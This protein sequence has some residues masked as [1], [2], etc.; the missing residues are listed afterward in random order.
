MLCRRHGL[1]NL[2]RVARHR[3]GDGELGGI[4]MIAAGGKGTRK[5]R[6]S[7]KSVEDGGLKV[8]E[9]EGEG[10]KGVGEIKDD[11]YV[12]LHVH[13]DFSLLD[14]A[15][16][17]ESLV[18][19]AVQMDIPA[20]ALTDHGVLYGAI[21]L[22]RACEKKGIKP[23][24]GNEMYMMNEEI[25]NGASRESGV[26]VKKY[27][28][29]VLAKNTVG[30]QNLVKLTSIAHLE[31]MR[32]R[33][34]FARPC[35]NKELL[36][37][38]R[39]GLIVCSACLG[40]EIPQA[41]LQGDLNAAERV[42]RWYRNL[43]GPD[44]YLELQDHARDEDKIVNEELVRL[45]FKLGIPLIA[46]N[47]SHFTT[48]LDAPAHDAL[49]CVKTGKLL[50]DEK[51]LRYT[52]QEFFKSAAEMRSMFVE[53]LPQR[54]VDKALQ[55]TVKL[56]GG[57][58]PYKIHAEKVIPDFPLPSSHSHLNHD[59]YLT[60]LARDGL[61]AI[62]DRRRSSAIAEEQ[63]RIYEERLEYELKMII[64]MGFTS[65]FLVVWDYIR[66]ARD[67]KIPV[68]PGRGS[69]AGSLVAF[70]LGITGIDPVQ[71]G[72]LFERFL[73]PDRNS[74]PDID[75]D[76][77]VEGREKVIEYVTNKYG[78]DRVA[79]I[80]TFNRLTTKAVLKDV[81]RVHGVSYSQA[82]ELAK[83]VPVFR[84]KPTT[85]TELIGRDLDAE[86]SGGAERAGKPGRKVAGAFKDFREK[87]NK[88]GVKEWVEKA[89]RIEGIN[90]G[91]SVHAAGV[92]ISSAPLTNLVPL[93]RAKHGEIIT[94]YPMEDVE[95]VGLLKMDFLGLK[96]LSVIEAVVKLINTRRPD[97][98][99][100]EVFDIDTIPMDDAKT[101]ELLASGFLDGVF[102][103]DASVGMQSIVRELAPSS[104]SDISSV[105]ALYRPG[106]LDAGLIPKFIARKHGREPIEYAHKLLE[107]IL[108]ETYGI[109]VY[110]EQIMSTAQVI[111]GY[112]MAQADML[113]RAMGKKKVKEM[114]EQRPR[115][116]SGAVK[117]GV[118]EEIATK[119][120]E[121]MMQFAHYC[122]NKSH[123]TAYAYLTYQ[124][125]YLKA[126]YPVEYMAGLLAACTKDPDRLQRLLGSASD[127]GIY[128]RPPDVN[129]SYMGFT[130]A[131]PEDSNPVI[132]FGLAAISGVGEG[133]ANAILQERELNGDYSS[134][135]ELSSRLEGRV[136]NK[137]ALSSLIYAGAFDGM[138]FNRK[139][140]RE[141]L[142]LILECRKKVRDRQAARER[143]SE[144]ERQK[145]MDPEASKSRPTLGCAVERCEEQKKLEWERAEIKLKETQAN[146][147]EWPLVEKLEYEKNAIG[148]Y[149]SGHPLD[150]LDSFCKVLSC[151]NTSSVAQEKNDEL[152]RILGVVTGLK[153]QT[154]SKGGK[155]GRLTIEDKIGRIPAI[156]FPSQYAVLE[157]RREN[158]A[159]SN[160]MSESRKIENGARVVV[161]GKIS[162]D[163]NSDG[164]LIVDDIIPVEDVE[165]LV[166]DILKSEC[167]KKVCFLQYHVAHHGGEGGAINSDEGDASFE[168]RRYRRRKNVDLSTKARIPVVVRK[169]GE[170]NSDESFVSLPARFR[171]TNS[172][173][174]Q[175]AIQSELKL[176]A[177]LLNFDAIQASELLTKE[178]HIEHSRNDDLAE[179]MDEEEPAA[180]SERR[181]A[182][183]RNVGEKTNLNNSSAERNGLVTRKLKS[184]FA[185]ILKRKNDV[186]VCEVALVGEQSNSEE[187][188]M[189]A[190]DQSSK[191][192]EEEEAVGTFVGSSDTSSK[193]KVQEPETEVANS[194]GEVVP[195][196][197]LEE[198]APKESS[199]DL[200]L[201]LRE[202]RRLYMRQERERRRLREQKKKENAERRQLTSLSR[203]QTVA[204]MHIES[205]SESMGM[206]TSVMMMDRTDGVDTSSLRRSSA[207]SY[208]AVPHKGSESAGYSID[209]SK[210]R[211]QSDVVN[212]L[213][214]MNERV[215]SIEVAMERLLGIDFTQGLFSGNFN[216][217]TSHKGKGGSKESASMVD[218]KAKQYMEVEQAKLG[219]G[220]YS[221]EAS[222]PG[223]S[224]GGTS[225]P[226]HKSSISTPFEGPLSEKL[227]QQTEESQSTS[228]RAGKDSK[229]QKPSRNE[230][231]G[232]VVDLIPKRCTK[233][234]YSTVLSLNA[235]TERSLLDASCFVAAEVASKHADQLP[236]SVIMCTVKAMDSDIDQGDCVLHGQIA[237]VRGRLMDIIVTGH[238]THP[239]GGRKS[240]RSLFSFLVTMEADLAVPPLA[241]ST[242]AAES[243]K[244]RA[245][246]HLKIASKRG[247]T[248][249]PRSS[250]GAISPEVSLITT[251][252]FDY[253]CAVNGDRGEL[254]MWMSTL[255]LRCGLGLTGFKRYAQ[256]GKI[257]SLFD[258]RMGSQATLKNC[259]LTAEIR[260]ADRDK[261][262]V[263]VAMHSGDE[264]DHTVAWASIEVTPPK[265]EPKT[266]LRVDRSHT[267]VKLD[268][269]QMLMRCTKT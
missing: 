43:F 108:S 251:P 84:G 85:L 70:A 130:V 3:R 164:Q 201:R 58:E 7:R 203:G 23:I 204:S 92:V 44:F 52:G 186:G 160:G 127:M 117:N 46:T 172:A 263:F 195:Y 182:R 233:S 254:L 102:Q 111:A 17:L 20:L 144:K 218:A 237:N 35:I 189:K 156:V 162:K 53:Y 78:A 193:L 18:D 19:R 74:M 250:R 37:E 9:K 231:E 168:G 138:H 262:T 211:R 15:S 61:C 11:V 129:K 228:D 248:K 256:L 30:Y 93:S 202:K 36:Y 101:Y 198:E 128:V 14:G 73:N 245:I 222:V 188:P 113:R 240:I 147:S 16:Q 253:E 114:A 226:S 216:M 181:E 259:V 77:S 64:R 112:T 123:S 257:V 54:I 83:A 194:T 132:L 260:A 152:V 221:S 2:V 234:S 96:N 183:E 184:T 236:R 246:R 266:D 239:T 89:R 49:I 104:L 55:N 65:Y 124:T 40:G 25:R 135:I 63:K 103:L 219:S 41:V 79:Q 90:K 180:I 150:D 249:Q 206:A 45:S 173:E 57:I 213:G 125:A 50:S 122:F 28:L 134:I 146:S 165:I 205:E 238:E 178:V 82:D 154:T 244:R 170:L 97:I 107:P 261:V 197:M 265:W 163:S 137:K 34:I 62:L 232:L 217:T 179:V 59:E 131:Y 136:L 142:D 71:H 98:G 86:C 151:N 21:Q 80:V 208:T 230:K 33:G 133:V 139:G 10:G 167:D 159:E 141:S 187:E 212:L 175:H 95:S 191:F 38:C 242:K 4:R 116:I 269:P 126:N 255:A 174:L 118:S 190:T 224:K 149:A 32:G 247:R 157:Q 140:V 227:V 72:L 171:C 39:D 243:R 75:T 223:M 155:M 176:D 120:F 148:F 60:T 109:L 105:L 13:S 88:P 241:D 209:R 169:T 214:S 185:S 145:A 192:S 119:L 252:N 12:P 110:Q 258:G 56:A 6:R 42:A 99:E 91:A 31:G 67:V 94:Q 196:T 200:E 69:V 24:V 81:A 267:A 1:Q 199:A 106:P 66:Y 87:Y 264:T 210:F 8:E 121:E 177:R 215:T 225:S 100:S 5:R 68:G 229:K 47:D 115:F 161:W 153:R 22:I 76:F 220:E 166:V 143:K 207:Q 158:I 26:G 268:C 27:H 51:R 235:S 29:I 48:E